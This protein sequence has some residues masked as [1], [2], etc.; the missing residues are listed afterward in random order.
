MSIPIGLSLAS[1]AASCVALVFATAPSAAPPPA[2][3]ISLPSGAHHA[4]VVASAAPAITHA[5]IVDLAILFIPAS[6]TRV[7]A[8]DNSVPRQC[9]VMKLIASVMG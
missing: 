9:S 5:R 7:Q 8:T 3:M 6:L 1:G 4:G 2:F